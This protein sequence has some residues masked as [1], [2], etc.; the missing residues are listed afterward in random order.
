M[1]VNLRRVRAALL[2]LASSFAITFVVNAIAV[3]GWNFVSHGV[4]AFN[5][6]AS[7]IIA[8]TV[9]IVLTVFEAWKDKE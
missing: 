9:S 1:P 2:Y 3:Y 4:G 7:L 8:T 6:P 5:W